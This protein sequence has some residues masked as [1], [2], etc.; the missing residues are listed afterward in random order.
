MFTYLTVAELAARLKVKPKTIRNKMTTGLF[1]EGIHY[2]RR[3]GLGA[4]FKRSAVGQW[5]ESGDTRHVED[6]D[7][8]PMAR[9]YALGGAVHT[10]DND[11]K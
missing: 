9:G 11:Q 5:I 2:S 6:S 3:P 10:V 4:R 1:T 7:S 8:I